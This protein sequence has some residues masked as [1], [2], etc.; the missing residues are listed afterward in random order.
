MSR[1]T[2][3]LAG[4]GVLTGI[5]GLAAAQA[6]AWGLQSSSGPIDAVA[7]AVGDYTPGSV[8]RWIVGK[9][10]QPEAPIVEIIVVVVLLALCAWL[11]TQFLKRPFLPGIAYVVFA[12]I[13][14][15]A[16]LRLGES[17]VESALGMAVGLVTWVV[18]TRIFTGPLVALGEDVADPGRRGFLIR[19]GAVAVVTALVSVVG[20][21]PRRRRQRVEQERLL[22]R[23][24]I[25]RG[26]PP[27]G[28]DLAIA[29]LTSWETA[30]EDFYEYKT[31]GVSVIPWYEWQLRIHGLVDQELVLTYEDLVNRPFTEAWITLCGV[32]NEVG[33]DV[34]GN[35][36]WSGVR[37]AD[38]LAEAGVQAGAD[39]VL[40]TSQ[41]GWTAETPLSALTDDRPALLAL[42]MN[43]APLELEHGFPVRSIVPG[44][45]GYASATKWLV[46]LEVTRFDQIES[47][48][49]KDGYAERGPVLTQSRIDL[50]EQGAEVAERSVQIGGMAWSPRTGIRTVEF[51]I[52]GS[53]WQ[54]A[55]L[56]AATKTNDTWVQWAAV[57]DLEPG[58]HVLVVRA[59]DRNGSVQTDVETKPKPSGATGWHQVEFSTV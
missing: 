3:Y 33:G 29:G 25:T 43:G 57:V 40:Q 24:P 31:G 51:Q 39:A 28:A 10:G 23:L 21:L 18:V 47:D 8:G 41:D 5:A 14:L 50:P 38:L 1:S 4:A 13:G 52:D 36:Y 55:E 46:D 26:T 49:V 16:I 12:L 15:G 22:L 2:P 56:G 44:L 54:T 37:V 32:T 19:F 6:T 11:G 35:A 17:T 27:A 30:T 45:Y 58:D 48:G 34:I 59:T 20:S 7:D 53:A 42:A 9:F